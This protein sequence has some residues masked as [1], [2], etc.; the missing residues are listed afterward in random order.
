MIVIESARHVALWTTGGREKTRLQVGNGPLRVVATA[1]RSRTAVLHPG[2]P[3]GKGSA[4]HADTA[5]ATL[6]TAQSGAFSVCRAWLYWYTALTRVGRHP[7]I[8]HI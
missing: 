5:E 7:R 2:P 1:V 4:A 8:L 6:Q 3:K